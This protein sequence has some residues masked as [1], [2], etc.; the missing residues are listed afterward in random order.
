MPCGSVWWKTPHLRAPEVT[1]AKTPPGWYRDKL[2]RLVRDHE[3][4]VPLSMGRLF[5][6]SLLIVVAGI[7]VGVGAVGVLLV[8]GYD[9]GPWATAYLVLCFGTIAFGLAFLGVRALRPRRTR[10]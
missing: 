7:V 2:G 6:G 8:W 9:G 5:I 1:S 4:Q 10:H 3:M